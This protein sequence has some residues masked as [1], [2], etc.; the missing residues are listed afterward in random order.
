[1]YRVEIWKYDKETD[2]YSQ[3]LTVEDLD[4]PND[5]EAIRTFEKTDWREPE[6]GR[7]YHVLFAEGDKV[8]A[9]AYTE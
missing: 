9:E 1:M 4:A 7:Q 3:Q 8:V 2:D 5:Q 6:S